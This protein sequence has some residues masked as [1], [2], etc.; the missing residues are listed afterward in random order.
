MRALHGTQL[1]PRVGQDVVLALEVQP[2]GGERA[3]QDL[4][5]LGVHARG[6]VGIDA[7]HPQLDR[8]DPAPD[9]QL[10][11]AAAER[12]Q[13]ADLLGEPHRVVQ[14]ER[15]D[16]RAEA[17]PRRALRDGRQE[18]ARRRRQAE[19]RPV[20]LGE[21]VR[22]EARPVVG[23]GQHETVLVLAPEVGDRAVHVVEDAEAHGR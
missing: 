23:L 15:V 5:P 8:R 17:Q 14:R 12:V 7:E 4:Q 3:Q 18:H 9:A 22:M 21:V 16:E 6:L 2:L 13:H 19:R 1:H 20:V 10:E 11:A